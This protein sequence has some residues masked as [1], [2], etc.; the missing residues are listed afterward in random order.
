MPGP[1]ISVIIPTYNRLPVLRTC[2]AA[3]KRQTVDPES[4]EVVVVDDGSTDGTG[5]AVADEAS[6]W[7]GRLV[8]L[9]Q[10]NSGANTAR[11]LGI[12]CARGAL[13]LI[14]NDD[15]IAAPELLA[16]HTEMHCRHP[17]ECVTVLGRVTI[18]PDVP[19]SP[20]APLHLDASYAGFGD[21]TELDWKAFFTCNISVKRSFLVRYGLFDPGFRW[22][23]DIELGER[24]RHHGLRVLYCP[25]AMAYHLHYLSVDDFLRIADKEGQSLARWYRVRPS[26]LATLYDIG[27]RTKSFPRVSLRYVLGDLLVNRLTW[28]PWLWAARVCVALNKSASR[29]IYCAVYQ[30][31]KRQAIAL[32]LARDRTGN[33]PV[34]G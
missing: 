2:L 24:L 3:L 30:A 6:S 4:F 11:N 19:A 27:L 34:G 20:V 13:L 14:I 12:D 23:E 15:S 33:A 16:E 5:E 29:S 21:R 26:L 1:H 17:E 28:R 31:R 32:G 9:R 18:S 25:T 7:N 10:A 8:Y 22:H